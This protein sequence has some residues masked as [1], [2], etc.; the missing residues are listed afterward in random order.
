MACTTSLSA[1]LAFIGGLEPENEPQAALAVQLA[2]L[3]SALMNVLGRLH[4]V[5]ERNMIAMASA[6]AKLERAFQAGLETYYRLKRGNS[7]VIRIERVTVE[8][9]AQ[10][11]IGIVDSI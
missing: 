2:A 10:A 5:T 4:G 8:A 1:A 3:H 11:V 7:Q 9:G 6:A